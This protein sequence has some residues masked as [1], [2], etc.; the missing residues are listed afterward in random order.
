MKKQK[1]ASH[2]QPLSTC[3]TT[4]M[5]RVQPTTKCTGQ[6]TFGRLGENFENK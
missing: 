5:G 1:A 4:Q 6:K 2:L 3:Q